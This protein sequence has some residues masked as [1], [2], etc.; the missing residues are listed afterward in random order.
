M[1]FIEVL[2]RLFSSRQ[3]IKN[4]SPVFLFVVYTCYKFNVVG[5]LELVWKNAE[6]N[7]PFLY[8]YFTT[9]HRPTS[10]WERTLT[11]FKNERERAARFLCVPLW[12]ISKQITDLR[13]KLSQT[14][15]KDSLNLHHKQP[16]QFVM[17][18]FKHKSLLV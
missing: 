16:Y 12:N 9:L 2:M 10:L 18:E 11:N 15:A 8:E 1:N 14:F 17:T 4:A 5:R 7:F 6:L 3:N 13:I